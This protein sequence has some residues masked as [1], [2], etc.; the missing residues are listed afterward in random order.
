MRFIEQPFAL[1][2]TAATVAEMEQRLCE[3]FDTVLE[4]ALER[5]EEG[6][7]VTQHNHSRYTVGISAEVPFGLTMERQL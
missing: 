7:L 2:V 1:E 4:H 6:I 3:A 5:G